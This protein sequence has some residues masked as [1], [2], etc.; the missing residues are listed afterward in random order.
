[1]TAIKKFRR[2]LQLFFSTAMLTC[3]FTNAVF[4]GE[5]ISVERSLNW[6][7]EL[8]IFSTLDQKAG[9]SLQF[10][11]AAFEFV[12][13]IILPV[14]G[15]AFSITSTAIVNVSLQNEVYETVV[16]LNEKQLTG[17]RTKLG[18]T[19]TINQS[20]GYAQKQA[21][22]DISFVPLRLNSTTGQLEKLVRFTIV[23]STS[24]NISYKL[25]GTDEFAEGSVLATGNWY[26][27][28][29]SKEGIFK[30]DRNWLNNNGLTGTISF[31][32]FGVFGNGGGMLPESNAAFRY[33]DLQENA[34]YK[35]D[36]N[37]NGFFEDGDYIY[38]YGQTQHRWF[39][40][41][42]LDKFTH[43][44]N[45]YS[46]KTYY[47]ITPD[48]GTG[49]YIQD[50][51][52][53]VTDNI[54]T[55]AYD[56]MS[57]IDNDKI[58]L[59]N[60]GRKWFSEI[61]DIYNPDRAYNFNM[62]GL[63]TSEPVLIRSNA[64]GASLSGSSVLTYKAN[65]ITLPT[66][67]VFSE[68]VPGFTETFAYDGNL[69]TTF[70][71]TGEN[72]TINI[73]F[74]G[75]SVSS[76]WLNFIEL[77]GRGNLKYNNAQFQF[78]ESNTIG[79]GNITKFII[80]AD[81]GVIIWDVTDRINVKN[82][83]YL[84]EGSNIIF[85]AVT[86]TL[87]NYILFNNSDV[88]SSSDVTFEEKIANQNIHNTAYQP[89]YVIVTHPAF[90][91]EARRLAAFHHDA[92]GLDTM[93][94]NVY[95][96]YNEFSSGAQDISAIRDMMRM[97]YERA[98]AD[99]EKMPRYLLLFGDGS[100]DYRFLAFD[101]NE[102]TLKVPNFESLESFTKT[103]SYGTD[104]YFGFLDPS[105]G[106]NIE[107]TNE[108]LDIGIGRLPVVTAE[109]ATQMVDKIL[110][111]KSPESLGSWRNALCFMADDEDYNQHVEDAD[112]LTNMI[113]EDY[114]TYN[115]DKIY[116]DS[117]Q[118]IPGAGG[119]RYPDVETGI[120]NKMFTGAFIMNYLGHGNEQNWAQERVLS[121]DDINT[122]DNYDKLPLFITATCSFSRYDNPGLRSAGEMVLLNPTGGGIA[123][124]TTVR[125][126]YASGNYDLNKNLLA[127]LFVKIDGAYPALGDAVKKGKNAVTSGAKN[128][129]K[130]ILLGDPA[131]VLNY[132]TYNVATKLV[133][134]FDVAVYTDTL[135]ALDKVTISG[136]ITDEAG[137]KLSGFNGTVYPAIYDKPITINNL[138]N[139]PT[140]SGVG[141]YG[142][143]EPF[144]FSLQK[145]ALYK[146]KASVVNGEFEFTFIVPRDISYSF[147]NGK[148]SYYADNGTEDANGY[149]T[150]VIIGG[151][152][153]NAPED[154]EGP[155]IDVYMNDETFVFGGLT[156]EN[157]VLLIKLNDNSGINA[158][159]NAVGHD[160]TATLDENQQ[161]LL[162]L[163]DYY[164]SDLD[165]YQ[166]GTVAYPLTD[167]AEGRH[168]V[169]VKAWDVYNN[170]GDGYTEFVVAETADL[171]LSHVLNYPNPF[172]TN[173]SFW[174]E[175]NRPGDVLDVKVE[176]FTVSGKRIKTIQQQVSTEG[177][178]VDNIEW[179]GLD[180]FGD[181]IGKG[182]YIYKVSVKAASD[183]SKADEFQKLV[184]LK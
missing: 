80:D 126:V 6:S 94:V 19:I 55:A 43:A 121:V 131:L 159:G 175:H 1:M 132:P 68:L 60:T 53:E 27:V 59:A 67:I 183:N 71:A 46:D 180:E 13:N 36:A 82:Q 12:D 152:A 143:S 62:P 145:N 64:A 181:A 141:G 101:E 4:A 110:H 120:N 160:I 156:D 118:Q 17:L 99:V 163:N 117:Y 32:D 114:P 129:R 85:R 174:F 93:V 63:I 91:S 83:L 48:Q 8:R 31:N 102:N 170:S 138:V 24:G 127:Q 134:G 79:A 111:Y 137:V 14:Y 11:G 74:S 167:I 56:V 109:E 172:T 119:E 37:G 107:H 77:I 39:Y 58:N 178:R 41:E 7:D 87:R 105:E 182:V 164:E 157:P 29:I 28:A 115:I 146:G 49:K 168:T 153:E 34:I 5:Q 9:E 162:K 50:K 158:L 2:Q 51:A 30:I 135:K 125:L 113:A 38:F 116:F 33:D 165:Q 52:S 88:F 142:P 100:F 96:V 18:K 92:Q 86:D 45:I 161:T 184:I 25:D 123:L 76:T 10:D 169:T 179:D 26:K 16:G 23:V 130:F 22:L 66:G 122:W 54:S 148:L 106:D 139:D 47:F 15:E 98:G 108:K 147:G 149:N 69:E 72:I 89:D 90:M 57:F 140:F 124:V 78:R 65:G 171:A 128:N 104:D 136:E 150:N 95:H 155:V 20:I 70:N 75:S 112:L 35:F 3:L 61:I 176:I 166:S 73:G 144:N 177:Y 97:F 133:N 44:N 84:T 81:P 103:E 151:T 173:T 40:N 21:Q 42:A 154:V